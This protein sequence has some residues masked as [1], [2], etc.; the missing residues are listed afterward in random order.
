MTEGTNDTPSGE[1][2]TPGV[3]ASVEPSVSTT[4]ALPERTVPEAADPVRELAEEVKELRKELAKQKQVKLPEAPKQEVVSSNPVLRFALVGW[5][6][7]YGK[8]IPRS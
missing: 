6:E 4:P 5:R 7:K 3:P 1:I 8:R 2:Q